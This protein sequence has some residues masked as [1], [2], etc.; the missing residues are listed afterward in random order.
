MSP[1][2]AILWV[3]EVGHPL[4]PYEQEGLVRFLRLG[5]TEALR[6]AVAADNRRMSG[7]TAELVSRRGQ[8][9]RRCGSRQERWEDLRFLK[10]AKMVEV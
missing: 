10:R 8:V 4:T 6:C 3:Q 1:E 7:D 9:Y 2:F 5:Y